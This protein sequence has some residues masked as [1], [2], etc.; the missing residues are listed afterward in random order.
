MFLLTPIWAET[1]WRIGLV[2]GLLLITFLSFLPI[3]VWWRSLVFLVMLSFLVGSFAMFLPASDSASAI[4]IRFP[5]ELSRINI[6][7]PAWEIVHIGALKLGPIAFGP[8][9]IDRRSAELGINT[10]T[11][12]FTVV[13]SV[14]LMLL[15]TT[16]EDL[17]WAI[18]WFMTPLKIFKL[19]IDRISFQLLLALRFLPLVQEELQNLFRSLLSRSINYKKL[20]FKGCINLGLSIGERLMVNILLRAEQGADALVSRGGK[21]LPPDQFRTQ[22]SQGKLSI[23]LNLLSGFILLMVIGL[24]KSYSIS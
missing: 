8:F 17:I 7:S 2:V 24:R 15:T 1:V 4:P 19:P 20:G 9:V 10:S 3:R 21:W 18:R 23:A 14:N 6:S 12:I 11:L 13:Q 16:P 22:G 5:N